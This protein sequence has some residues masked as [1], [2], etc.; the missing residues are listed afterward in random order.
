MP[1]YSFTCPSCGYWLYLA[2]NIA[3]RDDPA[4]CP[5][6]QTSLERRPDT[7]QGLFASSGSVRPPEPSPPTGTINLVGCSAI[8]NG[9]AAIRAS[10][11]HLNVRNFTA[12]DNGGPAFHLSD[13]ATVD[14]DSV[15]HIAR[16]NRKASSQK[17][18]SRKG[19]SRR[20]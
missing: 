20:G 16:D 6:C 18:K 13:G 11:G 4:T 19:R 3:N 7:T 12:I 10:A 8:G 17:K 9:G 5:Q 15:I 1:N 2:R 14:A